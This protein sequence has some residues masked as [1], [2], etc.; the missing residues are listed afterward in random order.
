MSLRKEKSLVISSHIKQKKNLNNGEVTATSISSRSFLYLKPNTTLLPSDNR[1]WNPN[2]TMMRTQNLTS[3]NSV[4]FSDKHCS[5]R[6]TNVWKKRKRNEMI[7]RSVENLISKAYSQVIFPNL[8]TTILVYVTA[9]LLSIA[10]TQAQSPFPANIP[11]PSGVSR[12]LEGPEGWSDSWQTTSWTEHRE[13]RAAD[14]STAKLDVV[15]STEQ[16]YED[17]SSR[18]RS[19]ADYQ[20]THWKDESWHKDKNWDKEKIGTMT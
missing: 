18:K 20:D 12:D 9:L 3:H 17:R 10:G 15:R 6:H 2:P 13:F 19:T 16:S 7:P 1:K 8:T 14:G 5:E 11:A 4:N